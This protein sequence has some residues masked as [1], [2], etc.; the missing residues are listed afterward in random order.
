M[1]E[2]GYGTFYEVHILGHKYILQNIHCAN[3]IQSHI[4]C[5]V[6]ITKKHSKQYLYNSLISCLQMYNWKALVPPENYE[7][8]AFIGK[9][10]YL[11]I[12]GSHR[13]FVTK[14][15]LVFC[16]F[17]PFL[18]YQ[19]N[20]VVYLLFKKEYLKLIEFVSKKFLIDNLD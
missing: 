13:L 17:D 3:Q 2:R 15:L 11:V 18:E 12:V 7:I 8:L 19:M 4:V 6:K 16:C 10:I 5:L 14:L 20:R 9:F 1:F